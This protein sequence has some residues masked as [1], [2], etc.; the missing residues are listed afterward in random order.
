MLSYMTCAPLYRYEALMTGEVAL[1]VF[2]FSLMVCRHRAA[3]N[4]TR[5][6]PVREMGIEPTR[7]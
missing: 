6:T 3:E 4:V 7:L 5:L 1:I 2:L